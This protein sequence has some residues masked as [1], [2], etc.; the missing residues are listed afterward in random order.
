MSNAAGY[1]T[2]GLSL[3]PLDL[4]LNNAGEQALADC[5]NAFRH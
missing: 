4:H 5:I 3:G 2:P 1:L